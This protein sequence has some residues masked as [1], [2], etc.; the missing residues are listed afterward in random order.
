M[1]TYGKVQVH[2]F[3]LERSIAIGNPMTASLASTLLIYPPKS[4]SASRN[5]V[6]SSP[7]THVEKSRCRSFDPCVTSQRLPPSGLD[8]SPLGS[9]AHDYLPCVYFVDLPTKES[10]CIEKQLLQ[11]PMHTY[12]KVR[13]HEILFAI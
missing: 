13:V 3:L 10:L 11:L 4:Q 8:R 5:S 6:S 12:G 1:H 7:C 9:G 2:G